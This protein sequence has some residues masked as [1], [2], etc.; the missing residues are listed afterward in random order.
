MKS[1][2]N[3]I[4]KEYYI[5]LLKFRNSNPDMDDKLNQWL[6]IIDDEDRGRIEMAK[7]KNEVIKEA[8]V[9]IKYFTAEEE[10]R[11]LADMRDLWESDRNSEIGWAKREAMKERKRRAGE[12]KVNVQ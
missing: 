11:Y 2:V 9:E 5:Q 10:A 12:E 3:S 6:T 4:S 1:Q 8:E 7:S